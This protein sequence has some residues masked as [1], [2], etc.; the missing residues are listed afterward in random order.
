MPWQADAR[1]VYL[2]PADPGF[3]R[4]DANFQ[5][6]GR[7]VTGP[8]GG[9]AFRTIRPVPYAGRAPHIHVGVAAPGRAPLVT[10]LW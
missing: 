1:G 9:Y 5:G 6:Y 7:T 10:Q 3:S 4:R 2:H 8:D